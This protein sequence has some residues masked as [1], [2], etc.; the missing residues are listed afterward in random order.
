MMMVMFIITV[1]LIL[2]G[3]N[4]KQKTFGGEAITFNVNVLSCTICFALIMHMTVMMIIVV[5]RMTVQICHCVTNISSKTHDSQPLHTNA[6]QNTWRAY[7][8]YTFSTFTYLSVRQLV[9]VHCT[10]VTS[11][12][13]IFIVFLQTLLTM[14]FLKA[15]DSHYPLNHWPLTHHSPWGPPVGTKSQL[16]PFFLS[17][18]SPNAHTQSSK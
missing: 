13:F 7:K 8:Y 16:L 5:A 9:R 15:Y 17:E 6:Y 10:G 2:H 11:H 14:Y 1:V 18:D 4:N 12:L 3:N